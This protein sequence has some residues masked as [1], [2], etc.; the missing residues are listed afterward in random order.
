MGIISER[1]E[2]LTVVRKRHT[3]EQADFA[4]NVKGL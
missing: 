1:R 2:L 3:A 4:S